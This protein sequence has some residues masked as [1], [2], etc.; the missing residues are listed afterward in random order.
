MNEANEVVNHLDYMNAILIVV[1]TLFVV[2]PVFFGFVYKQTKYRFS[3]LVPLFISFVAGLINL[4]I[5][6]NWFYSKNVYDLL[7]SQILVLTQMIFFIMGV[8][9][10]GNEFIRGV[11]NNSEKRAIETGK[12]ESYPISSRTKLFLAFFI[13][14]ATVFMT[15]KEKLKKGSNK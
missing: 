7:Q 9:I 2:T 14:C 11:K 15:L 1:T 5:I 6:L 13:V 8:F 12:S 10:V 4:A 3:L